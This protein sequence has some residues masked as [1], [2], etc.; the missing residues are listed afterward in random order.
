VGEP[1]DSEHRHLAGM[2]LEA[3][4]LLPRVGPTE[5]RV[6]GLPLSWFSRRPADFSG[7]RHPLRWTRWRLQVHR[8]GPYA[9][10]YKSEIDRP[11]N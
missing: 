10:D 3:G 2:P 8:L 6:L 5:Q 4:H 1:A 11:Q 7:L 9:P